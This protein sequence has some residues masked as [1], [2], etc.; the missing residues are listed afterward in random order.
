[1][2]R[3]CPI[4]GC[5][6]TPVSGKLMCLSHWRAVPSPQ[7][8]AVWNAWRVIRFKTNKPRHERLKDI[9]EYQSAR[10]AAIA[11]VART[12]SPLC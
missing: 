3:P 11:A 4:A 7:K 2:S 10:N 5:T 9:A 12:V 8:Y 1:M 6:E